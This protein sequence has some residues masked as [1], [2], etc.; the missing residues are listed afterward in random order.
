[1]NGVLPSDL[2]GGGMFFKSHKVKR[3][4]LLYFSIY[5]AYTNLSTHDVEPQLYAVVW[6]VV[7]IGVYHL[8][9]SGKLY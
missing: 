5:S 1:M 7:A 2:L 9:T 4:I 6:A 3:L 8:S